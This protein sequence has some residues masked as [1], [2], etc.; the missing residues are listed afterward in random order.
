MEKNFANKITLD[1]LAKLCTMS[2]SQ[3][4]KE[5][6]NYYNCTAFEKL[7]EIRLLNAQTRIQSNPGETVGM[8]ARQCG[9]EDVSYFCKAYKKMF[10]V[11][12]AADRIL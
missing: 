12:P 1:D 6:K 11:T 7:I 3:F 4:C 5:F 9:F 10:F 2:R 8:I